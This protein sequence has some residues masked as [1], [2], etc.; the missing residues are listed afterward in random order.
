[1]RHCI[2][3]FCH[4]VREEI[5][6]NFHSGRHNFNSSIYGGFDPPRKLYPVPVVVGYIL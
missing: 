5:F 2:P 4:S 3:F 1:M 6:P